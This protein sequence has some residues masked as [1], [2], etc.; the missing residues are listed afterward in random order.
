[1]AQFDSYSDLEM[2]C[3]G[4]GIFFEKLFAYLSQ[5]SYPREQDYRMVEVICS[6]LYSDMS[7][8]GDNGLA[9]GNR[10][11]S[12]N[13][14]QLLKRE[15]A[16]IHEIQFALCKFGGVRFII[17]V[18]GRAVE[19]R[20]SSAYFLDFVP[21]VLKF[22]TLLLGW[23]NRLLQDIFI[24]T[25]D[26]CLRE[27]K[28]PECNCFQGLQK[29]ARKCAV[30]LD[31]GVGVP[32]KAVQEIRVLRAISVL[33][34]FVG[35]ISRGANSKAQEYLSGKNWSSSSSSSSSRSQDVKIVDDL[36]VVARSTNT[37]MTKCVQFISSASFTE[38]L[39][40]LIWAP[41][42]SERRRF[43]AWHSPSSDVVRIA[44]FAYLI[45][46]INRSLMSLCSR[47]CDASIP[48]ALYNAMPVLEIVS[49]L[50]LEALSSVFDSN[51]AAFISLHP[52][53]RP[54]QWHGG[55]PFL[56]YDTYVKEMTR[57]QI[58][59]KDPDQEAILAARSHWG[60]L[61]HTTGF[62]LPRIA[63]KKTGD[64]SSHRTAFQRAFRV[65]KEFIRRLAKRTEESILSLVLCY[66]EVSEQ[67]NLTVGVANSFNFAMVL[68]NTDNAFKKRACAY[69]SYIHEYDTD[70]ADDDSIVKRVVQYITLLDALKELHPR[71]SSYLSAWYQERATSADK[72]DPRMLFGSIEILDIQNR[73]RRVFFPVPKF[74]LTYWSY[75][76]VRLARDALLQNVSR[77]SPEEKIRSFLVEMN[78]LIAVMRRQEA[79]NALLTPLVHSFLG[80]KVHFFSR[81]AMWYLPS[82]RALTLFIAFAFNIYQISL[83]SLSKSTYSSSHNLAEY[84]EQSSTSR[85]QILRLFAMVE[86]LLYGLLTCRRLVNSIAGDEVI[87]S[88]QPDARRSGS[89]L[90]ARLARVLCTAPTIVALCLADA[91]WL[92]FLST[93]AFFAWRWENYWVYAPC[94]L[95]V[96]FQI[97]QM[98]FLYVAITKNIVKI[99]YTMLLTFLLLYFAAFVA[100]FYVS[101]SYSF[102]GAYSKCSAADND[103]ILSCYLT[104]L[105]YGL[106]SAP[107]WPGDGFIRPVIPDEYTFP[108]SDVVS[109]VAGSVF[110]LLYVIVINLVLQAIISG[111]IIGT[112]Q[113]RALY[114]LRILT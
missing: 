25:F 63:A 83:V 18:L 4:G 27:K 76:E 42:G 87:R 98:Y 11:A 60:S 8:S 58:F 74:V 99:G 29:I 106:N 52:S 9:K 101:D 69:S 33:F 45:M 62:Q 20:E 79:L 112:V 113:Y 5:V 77:S 104:H 102:V 47:H 22:G 108:Y 28:V 105:D 110:Q 13:R 38:V 107:L 16:R 86:F 57:L 30:D 48:I 68:Q 103:T 59:H 35:S 89:R 100:Y 40:P 90:E 19:Q 56:F 84:L 7:V 95:D 2:W 51:A 34:D 78:G 96:V 39:C 41:M 81:Q 88:I 23:E 73:L 12:I 36:C 65:H 75:P 32:V 14:K 49:L 66:F 111:L 21:L 67:K 46:Q 50:S 97:K 61:Q 31:S 37:A 109:V 3:K 64:S 71:Y 85:M 43:V 17:S 55:E 93:C 10:T 91:K 94:L 53:E 80:G 24:D 72:D 26:D 70:E 114:F 92:L 82:L 1:V 15:A 54:I 6:M 44:A